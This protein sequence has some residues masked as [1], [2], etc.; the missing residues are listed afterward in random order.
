MGRGPFRAH[1]LPRLGERLIMWYKTSWLATV[2]VDDENTL[3]IHGCY[4]HVA[5]S[6]LPFTLKNQTVLS[7][8]S[9][10]RQ[11]CY[12]GWTRCESA[13]VPLLLDKS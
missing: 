4:I 8:S 7:K 2:R 10:P 11:E 1:V 13:S 3:I 5:V 6:F 12:A 9:P